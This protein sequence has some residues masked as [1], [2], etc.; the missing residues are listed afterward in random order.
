MTRAK[1]FDPAIHWEEIRREWRARVSAEYH[2]AAFTAELLHVLIRLGAPYDLLETA[3]RIVKDELVHA[4][5]SFAMLRAAGGEDQQI[6]LRAESLCLPRYSALPFEQAA[7]VAMSI[8]CLGE[9]FAVPL[10]RAMARR[11][12][13]PR[14]AAALRRILKDESVH[15]EFGWQLLDHLLEVDAARVRAL[16]EQHLPTFLAEYELGYGV[17]LDA[18]EVVTARE[19]PYGLMPRARYVS[20]F[21]EALRQVVIPRFTKRGIAAAKLWDER[22][23]S[24]SS[25]HP[26]PAPTTEVAS[27]EPPSRLLHHR[28]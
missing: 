25:L 26:A 21:E 4:E 8:F 22:R 2:S 5:R 9:T 7:C 18:P 6:A 1:R 16:A 23:S 28:T 13:H 15:R 11:T 10:F 24:P 12:T 17:P 3:H 14:A 19:E 20:T 27:L